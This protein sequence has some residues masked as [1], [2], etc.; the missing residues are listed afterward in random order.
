MPA[1]VE[2][3]L[4]S[5]HGAFASPERGSFLHSRRLA[6]LL[7]YRRCMIVVAD[8]RSRVRLGTVL[9]V[10]ALLLVPWAVALGVF[11][12]AEHVARNWDLAWAGFDVTLSVSLLLTAFGAL[13]ARSWLPIAATASGTLLLCDAWF[14][15]LTSS[16][17]T[18]LA[19]A[20]ALATLV[21]IPLAALCFLLA[22]RGHGEADP[23]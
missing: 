11:L 4:L 16:P 8:R 1:R 20:L 10:V 5:R 2:P 14:D 3:D 12:P 13:R 17:G 18:D 23:G 21:E 15:V 9:V 19:L 7:R 6:P 22:T